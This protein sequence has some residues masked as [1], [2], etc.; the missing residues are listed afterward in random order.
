M[1]CFKIGMG[2]WHFLILRKRFGQGLPI[3]ETRPIQTHKIRS[4][5]VL[6]SGGCRTKTACSLGGYDHGIKK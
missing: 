6:L 5:G 1:T 2:Y 4:Q 3:H